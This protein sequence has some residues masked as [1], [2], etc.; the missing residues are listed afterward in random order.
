MAKKAG[1]KKKG[2]SNSKKNNSSFTTNLV[3]SI[4]GFVLLFLLVVSIGLLARFLWLPETPV[5]PESETPK[6]II[7]ENDGPTFEIY[8]EREI[9]PF[10]PSTKPSVDVVEAKPKV[11]III[12]DV[13]YD[14][15]L[16]NQF[17]D[18]D[19]VITFSILPNSPHCKRIAQAA[20]KRGVE[21]MLHLPMEPIEYPNINPG[22]GAL[23]TS[24]SPDILIMQLNVNLDSVPFINGVNNHMG[25][26]MTK[27][28]TQ[29][30]QIFTI[31]KKRDLFF[32]DSRTTSETLCRPSARLLQIPFAERDVFLDNILEPD[33]IRGQIN[34][35]IDTA[36][37]QGEAIG[38]GHAHHITYEI[39]YEAI[40]YLEKKVN[41][42]PASK[43]VHVIG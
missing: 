35:L 38:I 2:S 37:D 18:L 21:T 22:P 14:R 13:G 11:S 25:S 33:A 31:L 5:K 17:L 16:A 8:P 39:L 7:K 10:E 12:D 32:I 27:I 23:L 42:V 3:K 29:M 15:R 36:Y 26:R 20:H 30:Y 4:A 34:V 41:L 40:E 19:S 9:P 6:Y 1:G 28:S 43:V 24:M